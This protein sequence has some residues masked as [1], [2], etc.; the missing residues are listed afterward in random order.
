MV[1]DIIWEVKKAILRTT[2]KRCTM[3]RNLYCTPQAELGVK[4]S[5]IEPCLL[6][7]LDIKRN[8]KQWYA[9][10]LMIPSYPGVKSLK[11]KKNYNQN[12]LKQLKKRNLQK[13]RTLS[14]MSNQSRKRTTSNNLI[15][16]RILKIL[17]PNL[18]HSMHNPSRHIEVSQHT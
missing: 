18:Y 1:E 16:K 13:G 4:S 15:N 5:E 2:G 10:K 8:W 14:L 11:K 7:R 17:Q 9:F 6:Y 3:V 12:H